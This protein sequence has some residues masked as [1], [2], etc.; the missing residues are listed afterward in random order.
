MT[1]WTDEHTGEYADHAGARQETD[2][3][4]HR[5]TNGDRL[6]EPW[7]RESIGKSSANFSIERARRIGKLAV[8]QHPNNDPTKHRDV[9]Q[10]RYPRE[11]RGAEA[12]SGFTKNFGN[13]GDALGKRPLCQR[14]F[15]RD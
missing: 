7:W 5:Q 2:Y 13:Q 10:P 4:E 3:F 8:P 12:L 6:A 1:D 15:P 14:M 9:Q 11:D